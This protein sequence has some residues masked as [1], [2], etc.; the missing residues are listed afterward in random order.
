MGA[1]NRRR[2][3]ALGHVNGMLWS[4]GNGLTTGTLVNYL[5]IDLGASGLAFSLVLASPQIVSALR[6]A[7]PTLIRGRPAPPARV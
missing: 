5:A 1:I 2:S 4:V 7:A 6:V 3:L